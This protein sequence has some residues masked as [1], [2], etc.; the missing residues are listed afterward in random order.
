MLDISFASHRPFLQANSLNPQKLFLL[1]RVKAST[2]AAH[3]RPPTA[4]V[5][6]MDTSG[7]MRELIT[8]PDQVTGRVVQVDGRTYEEVIGGQT[9]QDLLMTA[10][11]G[12][13]DLPELTE[14]DQFALVRFDDKASVLAPLGTA[15]ARTRLHNQ[16]DALKHFSGG[17][18]IGQGL[19]LALR[20]FSKITTPCN[21][22]VVLLTDGQTNDE[23]Y[24]REISQAFSAAHIPITTIGVG[25]EYNEDLLLDLAENT[26]G[27]P[28]HVVIQDARPPSINATALPQWFAQQWQAISKEVITNLTLT[29]RT[30]KEVNLDRITRVYPFQAEVDVAAVPFNLGNT[31]AREPSLFV[32]EFSLPQ[33]PVTKVRLAQLQFTYE[34]PGL[35]FQGSLATQE[36]VVEFSDDPALINKLD[37]EVMGYVQQRNLDALVRQ[38]TKQARNDPQKAAETLA[39]ARQM[40]QRLGNRS[41]TMA[42]D[43]AASELKQTGTLSADTTKTVRIGAKT[44]TIKLQESGQNLPTDA[45]I[46]RLTGA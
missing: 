36:V 42:L 8:E 16:I 41:M 22:R 34:V 2:E 31:D 33:R 45:E 17:T 28:V 26:Q 38:A 3:T 29:V 40:T 6:V 11:H 7:S 21:R 44:Q 13:V 30:V 4:T 23:S 15:T 32:L 12:V 18:M 19:K 25:S 46:R 5:F 10:L 9:K 20:E 14:Q 1:I 35:G 39:I 24:C 27:Q 43:R 37:P